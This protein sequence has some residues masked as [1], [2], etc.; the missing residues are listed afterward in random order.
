MDTATLYESNNKAV[1]GG[2]MEPD[3]ARFRANLRPV[4]GGN[5]PYLQQQNYSLAALAKRDAGPDPFATSRPVPTSTPASQPEKHL[6]DQD[7]EFF[8][9]EL[10]KELVSA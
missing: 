1:G 4:P 8:E 9:S 3:E 10:S 2:W 7:L 5:T 6:D